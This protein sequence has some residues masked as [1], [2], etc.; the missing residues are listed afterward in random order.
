M[1]PTKTF[2][3]HE[4]RPFSSSYN[5]VVSLVPNSACTYLVVA[6]LKS[7]GIGVKLWESNN[8][9]FQIK[10]KNKFYLK[11]V[12]DLVLTWYKIYLNKGYF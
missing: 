2:P 5:K 7:F 3:I 9:T 8:K 6:Y 10:K 4:S 11:N 1:E 12:I